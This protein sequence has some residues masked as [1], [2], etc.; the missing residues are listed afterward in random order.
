MS[1]DYRFLRKE[2]SKFID[3]LRTEI[4]R[5]YGSNIPPEALTKLA[6]AS[7]ISRST[8]AAW[9]YGDTLQP[10]AITLQFVFENLPNP[11]KFAVIRDDGSQV[12][13]RRS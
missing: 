3:L 6:Y 12:R 1:G 5:Q 9:L 11:C 2:K 13:G 8:I 7:G 4:Q 10:Q